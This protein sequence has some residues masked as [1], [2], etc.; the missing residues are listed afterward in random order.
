MSAPLM[1]LAES[2]TALVN[3]SFDSGEMLS[4]VSPM[5]LELLTFWF[6]PA[7]IDQRPINFHEWQRQAI[8]NTIYSHEI[9]GVTSV[10]D[11][12]IWKSILPSYLRT[13]SG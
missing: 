10:R 9:L 1:P 8:L 13:M 6:D 4:K 5:T 12:Y 7:Y 2:L 3:S 11:I